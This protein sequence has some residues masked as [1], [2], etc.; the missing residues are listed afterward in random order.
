MPARPLLEGHRLPFRLGPPSNALRR[1]GDFWREIHP[2]PMISR[3]STVPGAASAC[4][5]IKSALRPERSSPL[6]AHRTLLHL[7]SAS[8]TVSRDSLFIGAASQTHQSSL[9]PALRRFWM[10]RRSLGEDRPQS[11]SDSLQPVGGRVAHRTSAHKGLVG[12]DYRREQP[13]GETEIQIERPT[14]EIER[15]ASS[16]WPCMPKTRNFRTSM[17]HKGRSLTT[18]P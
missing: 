12:R 16:P 6:R 3:S 8:S 15:R 4:E 14:R 10:Y 17:F 9:P 18:L 13:M 11:L 2:P 5:V 1:S 7:V